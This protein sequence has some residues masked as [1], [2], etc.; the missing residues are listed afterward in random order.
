M[1][2]EN[3]M[4]EMIRGKKIVD[5]NHRMIHYYA[6]EDGNF[7]FIDEKGQKMTAKMPDHDNY[8]VFVIK[9]TRTL[10]GFTTKAC[11]ELLRSDEFSKSQISF[12]MEKTKQSYVEIRISWEEE[13]R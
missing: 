9:K 5:K 3:A 13:E 7:K 6:F 2:K 11:M 12:S 8:E 10:R 1:N 4:I